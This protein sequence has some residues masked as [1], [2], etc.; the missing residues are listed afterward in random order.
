MSSRWNLNA[1]LVKKFVTKKIVAIRKRSELFVGCVIVA[2][3]NFDKD[4]W[5]AAL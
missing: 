3:I 4:Q 5:A 2:F 1:K